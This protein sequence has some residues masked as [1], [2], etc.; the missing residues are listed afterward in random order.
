MAGRKVAGVL[1]A[2]AY[3]AQD[4]A[5]V[6]AVHLYTYLFL[7]HLFLSLSIN[8]YFLY[9]KIY[10]CSCLS[11]FVLTVQLLESIYLPIHPS[12][13]LISGLV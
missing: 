7:F 13:Y 12:I 6:D 9:V 11:K 5:Q 8:L 3:A 4:V 1:P 10:L 2:R